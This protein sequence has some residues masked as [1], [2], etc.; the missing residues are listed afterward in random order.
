MSKSDELCTKNDELCIENEEFCIENEEFCMT[1]DEFCIKMM[2]SAGFQPTGRFY[3][4]YYSV[5]KIHQFSTAVWPII[6]YWPV[7]VVNDGDPPG[8]AG[9]FSMEESGFPVEE[10]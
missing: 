10:C 8:G 3:G 4:Q 9:Q 1:N 5:D 2:N 7:Q 6:R